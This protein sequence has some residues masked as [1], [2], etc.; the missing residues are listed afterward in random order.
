[1]ETSIKR[2]FTGKIWI[3]KNIWL[4]NCLW[5]NCDGEKQVQYNT[6]EF[7]KNEQQLKVTFVFKRA[8]QIRHLK[9][10][11]SYRNSREQALT[12]SLAKLAIFPLPLWFIKAGTISSWAWHKFYQN[13]FELLQLMFLHTH[14][15]IDLASFL[16]PLNAITSALAFKVIWGKIC[17]Q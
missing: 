3:L 6:V 4:A 14:F 10:Y 13:N 15:A 16:L 8:K 1:M 12:Y 5:K 2:K 9:I 11:V 7:T 17:Q